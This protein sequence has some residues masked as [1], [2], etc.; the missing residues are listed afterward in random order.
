MKPLYAG[1]IGY[2]STGSDRC[3]WGT[4]VKSRGKHWETRG[5]YFSPWYG[6]SLCVEHMFVG[7][8]LNRAAYLPWLDEGV[9]VRQLKMRSVHLFFLLSQGND[10]E[11]C[12]CSPERRTDEEWSCPASTLSDAG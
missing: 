12:H 3:C 7:S 8:I 1:N 6:I 11:R 5:L 10:A 2:G 9:R 4:A